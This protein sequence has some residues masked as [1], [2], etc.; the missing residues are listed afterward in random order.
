MNIINLLILLTL[1]VS[2]YLLIYYKSKDH[3]QSKNTQPSSSSLV[4]SSLNPNEYYPTLVDNTNSAQSLVT[5]PLDLN[6][7][8]ST[9]TLFVKD[10]SANFN[11]TSASALNLEKNGTGNLL[12]QINPTTT[13]LLPQGTSG[14][15]LISQLNSVPIWSN[16]P[17]PTSTYMF[18]NAAFFCLFGFRCL[19]PSFD[20][21]GQF[22]FFGI[23]FLITM[24]KNVV[25]GIRR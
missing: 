21:H 20:C 1:I 3:K 13:S 12:V 17:A 11:G 2:L 10:I 4:K 6:Y 23:L 19:A 15:V 24:V 8:I 16:A 9:G 14:Q 7:N 25:F 18:P 22:F 5:D